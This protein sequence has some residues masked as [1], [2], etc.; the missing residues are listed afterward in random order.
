MKK[1]KKEWAMSKPE[2]FRYR[3][4]QIALK[5]DEHLTATFRILEVFIKD[6]Y[7]DYGLD[8]T[9]FMRGKEVREDLKLF[10]SGNFNA[11]ESSTLLSCISEL[12][13][14][15]KEIAGF[16]GDWVVRDG[17]LKHSKIIMPVLSGEALEKSL[18]TAGFREDVSSAVASIFAEAENRMSGSE[19]LS[20]KTYGTRTPNNTNTGKFRPASAAA[21]RDFE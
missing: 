15:M 8:D 5:G 3:I 14:L 11:E 20:G 9:G 17:K 7:P 12:V 6:K 4:S 18:A 1:L 21:R 19:E 10:V 2:L 13:S 16:Q